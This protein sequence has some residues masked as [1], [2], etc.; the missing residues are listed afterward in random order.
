MAGIDK[1]NAEP[2]T[3]PIVE[4]IAGKAWNDAFEVA[5]KVAERRI[6]AGRAESIPDAL[7]ALIFKA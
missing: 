7:R 3:S 4:A 1:L 2:E 5:I 6:Q